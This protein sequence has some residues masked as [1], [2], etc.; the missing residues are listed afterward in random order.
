MHPHLDALLNSEAV[1]MMLSVIGAE[2]GHMALR[3]LARGGVY[4]AGGITPKVGYPGLSAVQPAAGGFVAKRYGL[5][6]VDRLHFGGLQTAFLS[7]K[8]RFSNFLETI[9]LYVV[10]DEKVYALHLRFSGGGAMTNCREFFTPKLCCAPRLACSDL[11]F[12]PS[13]C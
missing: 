8:G 6:V 5:Q 4:I 7:R 13:R 2:A 11:V 12:V 9:P 10:L 1:D 3:A